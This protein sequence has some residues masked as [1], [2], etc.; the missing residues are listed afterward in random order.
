MQKKLIQEIEGYQ[1][2]L[3]NNI[4]SNAL[5]LS[6][7]NRH[8]Q[9]SFSSIELLYKNEQF[10]HAKYLGFILIDQLAWLISGNQWQVNVYFKDWINKYFIKYYPGISADEI[11]A[12]RNGHLHCNSSI[13]RDIETNKVS[14][15]LWFVD[16]LKNADDIGVHAEVP[17]V[18]FFPVNTYRFLQ[19]ALYR[20]VTDFMLELQGE[21][22]FDLED[23]QVKLGKVLQP[24][25]LE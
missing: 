22:F 3:D 21:N 23:I 10:S 25:H 9:N 7:L 17:L 13:S 12:S 24:M 14:R 19:V 2:F 1:E 15:Q 4:D 16:D 8:I 11:W 18:L 5:D 6:N 20:A